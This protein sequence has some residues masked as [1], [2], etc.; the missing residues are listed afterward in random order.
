MSIFN[1]PEAQPDEADRPDDDPLRRFRNWRGFMAAAV[2][3]NLLFIYGMLNNMGDANVAIWFKVL[4]WL[5]FN[6]IATALYLV[7]LIKL[8]KA[9]EANNHTGGAFYALLSVFMICANW[10]ML[11]NA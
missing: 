4:A 8:G 1:A 9:S 7:F 11:I 3:V 6:A 10:I 2:A 5:P